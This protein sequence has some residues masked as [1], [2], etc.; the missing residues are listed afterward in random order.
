MK[1]LNVLAVAA[2]LCAA[3]FSSFVSD[4]ATGRK[5]TTAHSNEVMTV[6]REFPLA[7]NVIWSTVGKDQVAIFKE[8]DKEIK[9]TF[10][11]MGRLESTLITTCNAQYLP[12]EL[13][14]SLYERFPGYVPQT[15][16]EYIR[17]GENSFYVLLK[18]S[19]GNEVKWL[20]VK[21]DEDGNAISVI[22]SLRQKV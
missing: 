20:R 19:Q 13:Q 22:Q 14:T 7:Q 1:K 4:A 16:S 6:H 17:T 2:I 8:A 21:S 5:S 10:N 9:C 11:R 3:T 18:S 15:V 12:F